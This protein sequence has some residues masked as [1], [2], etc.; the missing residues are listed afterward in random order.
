MGCKSANSAKVRFPGAY[1]RGGLGARA[2]LDP[3]Y[4]EKIPFYVMSAPHMYNGLKQILRQP[5]AWMPSSKLCSRW[6][7]KQQLELSSCKKLPWVP[8]DMNKTII[9]CSCGRA[10]GAN[11]VKR[12]PT[13]FWHR[14]CL[15]GPVSRGLT[16][17]RRGTQFSQNTTP[18]C[19]NN[20]HAKI[21][22]KRAKE[23]V[24][25]VI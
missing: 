6:P 1:A 16:L 4:R 2:P 17:C 3:G 21:V 5:P 23:D 18:A 12:R 22:A 8:V 15:D 19:Y 13:T 7:V 11:I 10:S 24:K 25:I 20:A 14:C 9:I